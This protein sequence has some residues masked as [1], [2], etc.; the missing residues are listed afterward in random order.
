MSD[1][2]FPFNREEGI[3][4]ASIEKWHK[5]RDGL[6]TSHNRR[7]EDEVKTR[8]E[9]FRVRFDEFPKDVFSIIYFFRLG[10]G[11]EYISKERL[12]YKMNRI[13]RWSKMDDKTFDKYLTRLHKMNFGAYQFVVSENYVALF[14]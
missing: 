6:I 13:R 10:E 2:D 5:A 4:V 3:F 1:D 14:N 9:P 11:H 12:R 8:F 7:R